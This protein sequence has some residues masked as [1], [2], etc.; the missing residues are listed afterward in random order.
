MRESF[1]FL[2]V[3]SG[4]AG[5]TT[6]L[7]LAGAGS[8]AIVTKKEDRASATNYAQGG[9]ATVLSPLDGIDSHLEDTLVAGAG[10]CNREAVHLMVSEGP[11]L[12]GE[13]IALGVEFNRSAGSFEV[14]GR[15]ESPDGGEPLSLGR[16]GGHTHS[17]IVHVHDLT[18]REV[19]RALV[20]AAS[21]HPNI[22][23]FEN[24]VGVDLI[25]EHHLEGIPNGPGSQRSVYGAYV[26]S[27]EIEEVIAFTARITIL[28]TGGCGQVY[29]HTT[30]PDIST[31]D[32]LAMAVRAGCSLAN[33][34]F[35]QFHP[36][37]L[38]GT[39]DPAFLIS[40]AV[41]GFGGILRNH[42]GE[43]FMDGVHPLRDL[44]PRDIVARAIDG[45][46]KSS[47]QPFVYL[48][49]T[50]RAAREIEERFPHIVETTRR[51]GID[52]ACDMFPV[53][54]AAHYMCGGIPTDL[55]GR[56][57]MKNLFAVGEVACTG[58]H[59]AN[60]LASNS[61][62]EGLVFAEQ[63]AI[64]AR[65]LLEKMDT[66]TI[67]SPSW[68]AAGTRKTAER[69]LLSHDRNEIRSLMWDYIGLVRSTDRL[70][71]AERRLTV[72]A[73]ETERYY[74]WTRLT[75]ELLELRNISQV[76]LLIARAARRRKESRGLH[77]MTDYPE[78]DPAMDGKDT[79]VTFDWTVVS[80]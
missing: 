12:I 31:G 67:E 65:E 1:D 28:A 60:R 2:I 71:R 55:R 41:R 64:C 49:L 32:G 23:I 34:E 21:A 74:R 70:E 42:A 19:E 54:P 62:L 47:G 38:Y 29:L 78:L 58:V 6:A 3:G 69:V 9:I 66:P 63:A 16:E 22:T 5:L 73:Q 80:P 57:D 50:H 45:Q 72:I 61:L 26:L 15:G 59:G 17:R 20:E 13:L 76:A 4:I 44:A 52:P 27:T 10:L 37:A 33:L 7:K 79:I 11:R 48:D 51:L 35:M 43:A 30:N 14:E 77:F 68:D 18:G 36:T 53:V 75:A 25:T 56:T 40:E 39:G 24:H 8:V 46:L